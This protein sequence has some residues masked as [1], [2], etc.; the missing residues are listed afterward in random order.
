MWSIRSDGLK[1]NFQKESI[2]DVEPIKEEWWEVGKSEIPKSSIPASK[3]VDV[4]GDPSCS[5][6][7]NAFDFR[8]FSC[9]KRYC[10]NHKNTGKDCKF[11]ET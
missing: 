3:N 6:G 5:T 4:C 1:K 9:R 2:S 11:C 10:D 8:C 7:V